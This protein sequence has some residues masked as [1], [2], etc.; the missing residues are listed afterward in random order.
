MS[1][2]HTLKLWEKT[3]LKSTSDR[4]IK[5]YNYYS[6]IGTSTSFSL[7]LA[8]FSSPLVLFF[9]GRLLLKENL[10]MAMGQI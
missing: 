5:D 7:S 2:E 9:F 6:Q 8:A 1:W 10:G 3:K 4:P